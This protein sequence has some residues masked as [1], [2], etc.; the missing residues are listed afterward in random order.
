MKT[1]IIAVVLSLLLAGFFLHAQNVNK[2]DSPKKQTR[3]MQ[4]YNKAWKYV[5]SLETLD[6]PKTI[7]PV[8]QDIYAGAKADNNVPQQIKALQYILRY[9]NKLEENAADKNYQ[10][11]KKEI[12]ASTQPAKAI[13][14]AILAQNLNDYYNNNSWEILGQTRLEQKTPDSLAHWNV[15][16]FEREISNWHLLSISEKAILQKQP[17]RKFEKILETQPGSDT[18][19]PTLYDLLANTAL[20]YFTS[21]DVGFTSI[22]NQQDISN[23]QLFADAKVF[24]ALSIYGALPQLDKADNRIQ[25]L[26]IYQ[27]LLTFHLADKDPYA[28]TDADLGRLQFV[29][30]IFTAGTKD[31]DYYNALL[32]VEN[33]VTGHESAAEAGYTR[34]KFILEGYRPKDADTSASLPGIAL[35]VCEKYMAKFPNSFG[36]RNCAHLRSGILQKEFSV[37]TEQTYLPSAPLKF[38][39]Q[40]KNIA[41]VYYR[42][43]SL[44]PDLYKK[45]S[46]SFDS[47]THAQLVKFSAVQQSQANVTGAEDLLQHSTEIMLQPLATGL[48]ALLVSADKDFSY[49]K[50]KISYTK[51]A[52]TNL[53]AITETRPLDNKTLLYIRNAKNGS[54]VK[55]AEVKIYRSEYDGNTRQYLPVLVETKTTRKDG[56][57]EL[58]PGEYYGSYTLEIRKDKDLLPVNEGFTVNRYYPEERQQVRTFFF[59]DRS[60]YRPGQTIYFKGIRLQNNEKGTDAQLI[61]NQQATVSFNDANGQLISQKDFTTNEFGSYNGSFLIPTNLLNGS[62]ILQDDAGT[63]TVQVEEYKRPQFEVRLDTMKS[64]YRLNENILLTGKAETYSGASLNNAKVRYRITRQAHFPVWM[65]W[66]SFPYA[67]AAEI[68]NGVTQTDANGKFK[69]DFTALPDLRIPKDDKPEFTYSIFTEVTSQSG[70]TQ[71]AE[72][73]LNIGYSAVRAQIQMEEWN[74]TEWLALHVETTDLSGQQVSLLGNIKIE[75]LHAPGTIFRQRLWEAPDKPII[76]KEDH[77]KYFPSDVYMNEHLPGNLPVEKTILNVTNRTS[78][79]LIFNKYGATKNPDPVFPAGYYKV[80]FTAKDTF[81]QEVEAVKYVKVYDTKVKK[82]VYNEYVYFIPHKTK[83]IEPG[84]KAVFLVGSAADVT[85]HVVAE[86]GGKVVFDKWINLKNKQQQVEIPVNE[87]HRGGLFLKVTTTA[88]NRFYEIRHKIDVPWPQRNLEITTSTWR[89]KTKPGAKEKWTFRI[90]GPGAEKA[91]AE[92]LAVMYDASLDAFLPHNWNFNIDPQLYP[93]LYTGTLGFGGTAHGLVHQ[94]SWNENI[95][96]RYRYYDKLNDFGH[97]GYMAKGGVYDYYYMADGMADEVVNVKRSSSGKGDG[98]PRPQAMNESS[99]S[100]QSIQFSPPNIEEQQSA[101]QQKPPMQVRKNKQELAFFYPQLR[102]DENG[103]V[104]F[105]FTMPDAL[106]R[107]KFMAFAHTKELKYGSFVN[108]IVTQKELM[109][110]PNLPRFLREGDEIEFSAGVTNLSGGALKGEIRI[111]LF[112]AY[113]MKYLGDEMLQNKATA[114]QGI[115][116]QNGE[117]KNISW[118]IKTPAGVDAIT[119]QLIVTSAKFS[120]GEEGIIPVLPNRIMVTETLPMFVR[121]SQSKN[122]TFNALTNSGKTASPYK[123]TL[124]ITSNPSWFAVQALPYLMESQYENAEQVFNRFYANAISQ[125]ILKNNAQIKQVFDSWKS[126]EKLISNLERNEELKNLLLQETPWLAEGRNETQRMHRIAML[127]DENNVAANME[128]AVFKL[129]QLQRPDGGWPWFEGMPTDRYITQLIVA[130]LGKLDNMHVRTEHLE[131]LRSMMIKAV[132]YMDEQAL[133]EYEQVQKNSPKNLT[134]NHLS[135]YIV[136]YFYARSYYKFVPMQ[137]QYQ[138]SYIYWQQQATK[139]WTKLDLHQKA[140]LAVAMRQIDNDAIAH[141]IMHSIDEHAQR[142]D[143]MGMYWKEAQTTGYYWYQ[144]PTETQALLIEAY[145]LIENDPAAVE[146]M[147]LWLLKQKQTQSWASTK[148]TADAVFAL[149]VTGRKNLA[150]QAQVKVFLGNALYDPAKAGIKPEQGTGYY[151]AS[152]SRT[153]IKPEQG[154]IKLQ[155]EDEGA[156]WGA[157]YYQYFQDLSAIKGT[158]GS[159][160]ISKELFIKENTS[161]GPQLKPFTAKTGLKTGDLVTVKMRI[162][163]DRNM[164]YVHIKDMRAAALEPTENISGYNWQGN[165]GY[166]QAIKDA[167]MNFFIS[168]L[169]KGEYTFE[170][171][172]RASQAGI[173]S[174]GISQIQCFYAPEFSGQTGSVKLSIE[175]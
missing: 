154:K 56:K 44:T 60:I 120:D 14:Q 81:G 163:T 170:Y 160:S 117:T 57:I 39:L 126:G 11:L 134:D 86:N 75:K 77:K 91:A 18:L 62:F 123:L 59:T 159:L 48:Y 144:Q 69:F 127:F 22:A 167:S 121:G 67:H 40:Y 24:S 110:Q 93:M 17:V 41:S 30:E 2:Q 32:N 116:L 148:A 84:Q 33:R 169:S 171:T 118:K 5:D 139:H 96:N 80:T 31:D 13:M 53:A 55:G 34:A 150:S 112:D 175:K 50:N 130:G 73:Y 122:F 92:M 111:K 99:L 136:Q 168:Y 114:Q 102:T 25:A 51:F 132:I 26:R 152:W 113:T 142:S 162:K 19:R 37:V 124:E 64:A 133:A 157:A 68:A 8:I 21:N 103:N 70:E 147:K 153:E 29:H 10:W 49:E 89:D 58:S 131:R 15:S 165:L 109:V 143:E 97:A 71:T 87:S 47:A 106:T 137:L 72:T 107:W 23:R 172:L 46:Y 146:E 164:E 94:R 28:L 140:M 83:E 16:D 38:A 7:M 6:L 43:V 76:T 36:G 98:A 151:K 158:S 166:Y 100:N 141:K 9:N 119:Y 3:K 88:D 20:G 66:R 156:A 128:A 35:Q 104:S 4:D 63:V 149:L 1:R 129:E 42:V 65:W 45:Y 79:P 52:V 145:N 174:N 155:K 105:E 108:N 135:S 90:A 27:D 138:K 12:A 78:Q 115:N 101:Q 61:K 85:V 173:F 82:A 95:E 125:H 161:K 74:N 54:A